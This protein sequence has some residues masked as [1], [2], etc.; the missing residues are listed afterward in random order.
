MAHLGRAEGNP[1]MVVCQK[2]LTGHPKGGAGAWMLNGCLQILQDGIVP[3]NRNADDV[4][5]ALR[6]FPHLLYPSEAIASR[7]SRRLC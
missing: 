7:A 1:L 2:Y 6:A 5:E 3:G 4:D